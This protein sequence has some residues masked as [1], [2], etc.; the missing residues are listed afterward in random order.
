MMCPFLNKR[1][2]QKDC[3]LWVPMDDKN[4]VC[5]FRHMATELFVIADVL[6]HVTG[7]KV[8]ENEQIQG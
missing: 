6:M 4:G 8:G 2:K 7:H 5:S 3:A 1:C